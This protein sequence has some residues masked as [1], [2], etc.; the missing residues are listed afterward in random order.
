MFEM[1]WDIARIC[2]SSWLSALGFNMLQPLGGESY[3]FS[4]QHKKKI[5]FISK[6]H[7]S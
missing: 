7:F 3:G 4:H 5:H 6:S 2:F 1:S